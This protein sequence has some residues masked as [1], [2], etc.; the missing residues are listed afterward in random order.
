MEWPS[1]EYLSSIIQYFSAYASVSTVFFFFWNVNMKI[2]DLTK[3]MS[4]SELLISL[5]WHVRRLLINY[6]RNISVNRL[7]F[8]SYRFHSTRWDRWWEGI[9]TTEWR[10]VWVPCTIEL[11]NYFSI[12]YLLYC[13]VKESRKHP[14]D[15]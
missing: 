10:I 9:I 12:I 11:M 5:H 2:D 6:E 15:L 4:E 14:T 7:A 1:F 8:I 3:L 13:I